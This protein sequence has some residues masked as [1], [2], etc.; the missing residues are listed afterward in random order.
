MPTE[1]QWEYACRAGTTTAYS[2]GDT[3]TTDEANY[4]ESGFSQTREVGRYNANP[5]GFYDMHGNV[6]ELT[7]DA[8]GSLTS[9]AQ[10]NPFNASGGATVRKGWFL[11]ECGKLF[12]LGS[13]LLS[14]KNYPFIWPWLPPC[15]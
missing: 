13:S 14:R 2:W 8:S 3:I 6:W 15:F 12:T 10:T 4:E 11:V 9:V 1:A 7:A 5:W